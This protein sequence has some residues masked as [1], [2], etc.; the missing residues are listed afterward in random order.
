MDENGSFSHHEAT[1][2]E[3]VE[4]AER[5]ETTEQ[6]YGGNRKGSADKKNGQVGKGKSGSSEGGP[7]V[8]HANDGGNRQRKKRAIATFTG[9]TVGT[10]A[11]N[12]KS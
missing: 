12:A 9:P 10:Q 1:L 11:I 3:L 6:R 2:Q 4:Y 7:E 8:G 5:L